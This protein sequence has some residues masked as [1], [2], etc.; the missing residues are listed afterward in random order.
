MICP[1]C[2]TACIKFGYFNC[3]C[4]RYRCNSCGKTFSDIPY[5]PLGRLKTPL[6]KATRIINLLVEGMGVRATALRVFQG[7]LAMSRTHAA[8]IRDAGENQPA[9]TKRR[10]PMKSRFTNQP[11]NTPI[12]TSPPAT[13]RTWRSRLMTFTVLRVTGKF[14]SI[15][16][17]VPPSTTMGCENLP[18]QISPPPLSRAGRCGTADKPAGLFASAVRPVSVHPA[19]RS[20]PAERGLLRT[21]PACARR[22]TAMMVGRENFLQFDGR[23][24]FH[25][26]QLF[27]SASTNA[28]PAPARPLPRACCKTRATDGRCFPTEMA[29][30]WLRAM[31]SGADGDAVFVEMPRDAF[32]RH[33]GNDE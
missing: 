23:D 12:N 8:K 25:D 7:I 29:D 18:L 21:P 16:A 4:Q 33:A 15:H 11:S 27:N 28:R 24:G 26:F 6:K 22:T 9:P 30:G 32:I 1:Q 14:A 19:E 13:M 3:R 2:K 31:M 20:A 10:Q 5:R 17:S